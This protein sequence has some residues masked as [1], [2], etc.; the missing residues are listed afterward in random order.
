MLVVSAFLC[1]PS[2]SP[3]TAPVSARLPRPPSDI[4]AFVRSQSLAGL[5]A[6]VLE[7]SLTDEDGLVF[8]AE[9][10]SPHDCPA[11]CFYSRAYGLQYGGRIGWVRVADYEGIDVTALDYFDVMADD[12]G[13]FTDAAWARAAE[14][15]E[16]F[17]WAAFL[18]MLAADIDTPA[19][20]AHRMAA[21]LSGW[22]SP[23]LA[24][25][26]LDR[27]V[28]AGDGDLLQILACLPVFQ[29]DAYGW[30]RERARE[31]LGDAFVPCPS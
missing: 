25:L 4:L 19:E 20:T 16:W 1:S 21:L 22:I 7:F 9:Y 11:G 8:W 27:A 2:C 24:S 14:E 10:G 26:L 13:L 31:A 28:A 17:L 29:G 6:V 15:D 3:V 12:D 30:V 23:Q 18:P 5:R